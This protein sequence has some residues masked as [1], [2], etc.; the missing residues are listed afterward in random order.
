MIVTT[1]AALVLLQDQDRPRPVSPRSLATVT[2]DGRPL[3]E[4]G[5]IRRGSVQ[6]PMRAVFEALGAT[7]E[8]TAST[9]LI[10]A[11]TTRK[12]IRLTVGQN[13]AFVPERTRLASPPTMINGK[14]YVPLRFVSEALGSLVRWEPE[15]RSVFVETRDRGDRPNRPG[16]NDG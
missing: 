13:V 1:L 9:Q 7:V 3:T 15:N 4:P 2:V 16:R 11:R 14:V 10:E 5:R 12:T 8:Y 6:V